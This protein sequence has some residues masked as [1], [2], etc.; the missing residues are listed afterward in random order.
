MTFSWSAWFH[1]KVIFGQRTTRCLPA[2]FLSWN[3]NEN[4]KN[5][6]K[7]SNW[8]LLQMSY[9]KT[10]DVT[11]VIDC[12]WLIV[13][14]FASGQISWRYPRSCWTFRGAFGNRRP[15]P[16]WPPPRRYRPRQYPRWLRC[17]A[18]CE[19]RRHHLTRQVRRSIRDSQ[20]DSQPREM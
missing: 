10:G 16:Q 13:I 15:F 6:V 8:W 4:R 3:Q 20:L 9:Y 14:R 11:V 19:P 18:S 2:Y 5:T 1:I 17:W 7:K 12:H